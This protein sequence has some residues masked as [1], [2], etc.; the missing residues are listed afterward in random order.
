MASQEFLEDGQIVKYTLANESRAEIE[1]WANMV[2]KSG[3][4]WD[5]KKPYFAIEDFRN[6]KVMTPNIHGFTSQVEEYFE[7]LGLEAAYVAILLGD[8]S[9]NNFVARIFVERELQDTENFKRR[10]FTN[11]ED[12]LSWLKQFL[13]QKID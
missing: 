8:K 9:R 1:G 7:S 10:V 4:T 11:E 6:V 13:P 2:M 3:E 5:I 12:A